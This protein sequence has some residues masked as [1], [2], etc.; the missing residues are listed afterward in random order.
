[1]ND[2][3][4][5][6]GFQRAR[7]AA[8]AARDLLS[9]YPNVCGIGVGTKQVAGH[10]TEVWCVSVS[11]VRKVPTGALRAA[12]RIPAEIQ[13]V[14][15]DV[16]EIGEMRPAVIDPEDH[17]ESYEL[18][19]Y[20]PLRGGIKLGYAYASTTGIQPDITNYGTMG[21]V[22]LSKEPSPR[23]LA[24]TN[25]HVVE[26]L[27]PH[28]PI[29][30]PH[31]GDTSSCCGSTEIIGNV[32]DYAHDTVTPTSTNIF[33]V[34]AAVCSLTAGLQWVAGVAPKASGTG[35]PPDTIA[36]VHDLSPSAT[37]T[38]T[39]N[40]AVHKRGARTG[41]TNGIIVNYDSATP[42]TV[43][44]RSFNGTKLTTD[45]GGDYY[46][47]LPVMVV[48]AAPAGPSFAITAATRAKP[49]QIT[50]PGM[51]FSNGDTVQIANAT[52]MTDLNGKGYRV[53]AVNSA[54]GTFTLSDPTGV[55]IDSTAFGTYTGGGTVALF[56]AFSDHGDSGSL[57]MD[58]GGNVVGLLISSNSG[59]TGTPS[60][61]LCLACHIQP[62][63]DALKVTLPTSLA[64]PGAQT[65]PAGN[66]PYTAITSVVQQNAMAKVQE[67]LLAT[68]HGVPV[69]RAILA[70]QREVRSLIRSNRRVAAVW[71]H[72]SAPDMASGFL[73]A[74]RNPDLPIVSIDSA[75]ARR[76]LT[77]FAA[78]LA[79][80]GSAELREDLRR[81]ADALVSMVGLTYRQ[82]LARL[83]E[84]PVGD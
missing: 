20:R 8:A 65:V 25:W 44:S 72:I 32:Y 55:P 50:A 39:P 24:L 36:G 82:V 34:D 64:S 76:R 63:L 3:S 2:A 80:F 43:G 69:A 54:A 19:T 10:P 74:V 26:A 16:L 40:L 42:I 53:G 78:V 61:A 57:I 27:L 5:H 35:V 9:R 22:V 17:L 11:V 38:P 60:G 81:I 29:G 71:S 37:S 58:A 18:N 14:P 66:N 15:T 4:G 68:Q 83:D 12:D 45:R 67:D 41:L 46:L 59:G 30:Q 31:D 51:T 7:A 75:V 48:Q 6:Q 84:M 13:G 52:G 28:G 73:D 1:M 70:H 79:R 77:R 56:A 62:V 49:C 47:T 23:H 21:C 33:P